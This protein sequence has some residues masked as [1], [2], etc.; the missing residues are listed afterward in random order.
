MPV[1]G[2]KLHVPAMRRRLV[3]VSAS[4]GPALKRSGPA[5]ALTYEV[6][7]VGHLDDHWSA[8]LGELTITRHHDG[9]SALAGPVADQAQLHGV[10]ARLR[11]IG[12][13]LLSLK[14]IEA[15]ATAATGSPVKPYPASPLS[16]LAGSRRA[17]PRRCSW[18]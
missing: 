14:A 3:L 13:T 1:L 5:P 9:T 7:V 8:W 10:L 16:W 11:D 12:V 15:C 6:R 17:G 4:A 18:I 2:T